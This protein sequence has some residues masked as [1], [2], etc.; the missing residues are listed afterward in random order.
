[1]RR[2]RVFF[3]GLFM[4][5]ALL[6]SKGIDAVGSGRASLPGFRLRIGRRATLVADDAGIVHG[7][8]G[9]LSHQ[10]LER[11]Y[12]DPSVRDYRPEG[13]VVRM[14]DGDQVP[15]LCFNLI[16]EPPPE[17]HNHDY[18]ARLRALAERLNLPA[19]YV[20]SIE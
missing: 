5:E 8:A 16:E 2:I 14:E 1:V 17:E 7:I 10:E 12:S 15:A 9:W 13:V 19:R 18:A 3:Y 6:R 4:D 11:L 20:A